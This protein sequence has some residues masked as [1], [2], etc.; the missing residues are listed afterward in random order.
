[1]LGAKRHPVLEAGVI[2]AALLLAAFVG[3]ELWKRRAAE[4][5][6]AERPIEAPE[7]SPGSIGVAAIAE[8]PPAPSLEPRARAAV[9]VGLP[10]KATRVERP[11][12]RRA[13]PP[14]PK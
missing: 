7:A 12:P 6:A 2:V 14:P 11:K 10:F 3:R 5:A 1:M 4:S 9:A 13:A 8:R